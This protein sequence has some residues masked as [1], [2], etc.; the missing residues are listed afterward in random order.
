MSKRHLETRQFTV[1]I[2]AEEDGGYHAFCPTLAGCHTQGESLEEV[3]ANIVE[4]IQ[5]HLGSLIKDHQP[6]PRLTQEFTG[7]VTV[8]LPAA[9]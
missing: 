2:E 1:V 3:K 6:I 7:T 8:P 5:C 4:A 9:R